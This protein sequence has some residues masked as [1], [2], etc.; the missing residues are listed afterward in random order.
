MVDGAVLLRRIWLLLL[1]VACDARA[2]QVGPHLT[3]SAAPATSA[4]VEAS[5]SGPAS[6][7]AVASAAVEPP[8]PPPLKAGGSV[9]SRYGMVASEDPVATKVGVEVLANGGNAIDAAVAV[10]YAL[11]VTHHSAGSL[12]GGGFMIVRLA[13]GE[14]HAIDYREMAPAR[15]TLEGNA[16]ALKKS[17]HGYASAPV[18]GV[19]AG[20]NLARDKFGTKPLAELLQPSITLSEQGHPYGARQALVMA[21]YWNK[22]NKDPTLRAV[23]GRGPGHRKP[24]GQ[25]AILKQPSLAKTLRAIADQGNDGFY[26]GDVAAS[27]ASAMKK[28]GG[29]VTEADLAAYEAVVREPLRISYRGFEVFTMPPPSMGGVALSSILLSLSATNAHAKPQGS[30]D[31]LHLFIEAARRAYADRRAVAADPRFVDQKLLATLLD[32][33]YHATREP[34]IDPERATPSAALTPIH[35]MP[36]IPESSNTTHFSVVDKDGNAVACTTTLSAAFGAWVVVPKTG[37]LL[38]NAMFGFSPAGINAVAPNKRMASSMTPTIIVRDGQAVA[39]VGS[40]GG[41]TIPGTVAQVVRNLIDYDNTIDVAVSTTRVH[42]QYKPDVA[43][44][45]KKKP[46]AKGVSAKLEEMGHKIEASPL[47]LGDANCVLFDPASGMAFGH[48][49]ER[50]G[51]LALGPTALRTATPDAPAPNP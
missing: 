47:L 37:I 42:H 19:V 36:T 50:K 24:V 25:G 17:A 32:P 45:E 5:A 43:R 16:K 18:P 20:L 15:A 35:A 44:L 33:K 12:G 13:N 38:S 40:P 11:S 3:P 8:P 46:L 26:K 4:T 22:I 34:I 49:D 2:P 9:S 7:S 14:T 39:A 30:A 21:W 10:G 48:A 27:I 41:D 51:G 6:A 31:S 28:R 29:L 23:F 1:V